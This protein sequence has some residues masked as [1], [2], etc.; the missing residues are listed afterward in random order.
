MLLVHSTVPGKAQEAKE[1]VESFN[2]LSHMVEVSFFVYQYE[3]M[4]LMKCRTRR[5]RR[6][7]R[8]VQ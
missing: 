2:T 8:W 7:D 5:T 6:A 4:H 1:A 3:Y